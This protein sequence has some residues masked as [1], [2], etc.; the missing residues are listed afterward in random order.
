MLKPIRCICALGVLLFV[1]A[2]CTQAQHQ[3]NA[4]QPPSA[5]SNKTVEADSDTSK[6]ISAILIASSKSKH[7]T[8]EQLSFLSNHVND[9]NNIVRLKVLAALTFA[10]PEQRPSAIAIARQGLKSTD[11]ATRLWALTTLDKLNPPDIVPIAKRMANDRSQYV[12]PEAE[13]ILKKR[14][15]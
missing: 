12:R 8:T 13:R 15:A 5:Q 9:V 3:Q 7:L 1:T 10:S 6:T 4:A 14:G 11:S 2:G